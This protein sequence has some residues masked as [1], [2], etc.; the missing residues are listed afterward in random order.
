M[1]FI[2]DPPTPERMCSVKNVFITL[3]FLLLFVLLSGCGQQPEPQPALTRVVVL[4]PTDEPKQIPTELPP[5]EEISDWIHIE[6]ITFSDWA[7]F[8]ILNP[9]FILS[10]EIVS[11]LG[12]PTFHE[13][14]TDRMVLEQ[15]ITAAKSGKSVGVT[16][17]FL[18]AERSGGLT[19]EFLSRRGG[20]NKNLVRVFDLKGDKK[21]LLLEAVHDQFNTTAQDELEISLLIIENP[22]DQAVDDT[23][24]DLIYHN[25]T[26]LTMENGAVASAIAVQDEFILEVGSDEEVLAYSGPDTALIDLEGRTLMPGF[27]DP[28]SHIFANW[29]GDPGGAQS[30][31]LSKGITAYAEMSAPEEILQGIVALDA[32]SKLRLRVSLYPA[33]V[34]VCGNVLGSWYLNDYP[35]TREA[36]A[37]LQIPGV[38]IFNDGGACNVPATSYSYSRR[39]DFGDLYFNEEEL[40]TMLIEI[41]SNDYQATI[42]SLGDRAIK[43]SQQAIAAALDG[44]PNTY[45][46][47][48]EHNAILPDELLPIYNEY[49][50]NALIF[51]YFPTC[52]FIGDTSKYKYVTPP[53]YKYLEW[54]WYPLIDANP[55]A[56]IA[57][58]ADSPPMG[59]Q[60]PFLHLHGFVTRKQIR[61][62]GTVCEPPEWAADDL[63][64]V[65]EALPMMTIKAAYALHRE[66]EIGSLK[67]GK[68]ADLIILSDNPLDVNPD[69]IRLIQVLMTMVGGQVEHCA[70]GHGDFC[71]NFP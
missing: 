31:I 8:H 42:H 11:T 60:D 3:G 34:D 18:V 30:D 69:D 57:W 56:H 28:H 12:D 64:I 13:V 54:R 53:E 55:D 20:L 48:I 36:G 2:A 33:H 65:E 14:K 37:M 22:Q 46:H 24:A 61:D 35:V 29:P 32:E 17:N 1:D 49:D 15:P 52:S 9:E 66:E 23:Q 71:P 70:A 51:G 25:G 68:L 41:Q 67:A 63:F 40:S 26:I 4:S 19:L 27:V 47:R 62:D 44:G 7:E 45:R 58:H 21:Q 59:P 39:T 38:K 6:F 10:F 43:V 16:A 5:E 50:I